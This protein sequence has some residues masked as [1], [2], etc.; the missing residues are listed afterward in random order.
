VD[1]TSGPAEGIAGAGR[2][3]VVDD[4]L[5]VR[6]MVGGFLRNA[7][8]RVHEAENGGAAVRC[9]ESEEFDVVITDL[10]MP[11]LDGFGV[12]E[13]VKRR[14][15]NTEVIIL[16]GSHAQDMNCAIKALRLGAHDFLTKPPSGPDE[17]VLTVDRALEKKRLKEANLRLLRQLEALSRTDALTGA[18]NRRAFDDTLRQERERARRY[19][20]SLSLIL[21]DL[22]HFKAVND[23]HGHM[24]GDEVLKE[25]VRLAGTVFRDSDGLYRYGGEEF[26]VLMP[27]TVLGGALLAAGRMVSATADTAFRSGSLTMRV[28][29][30]AGVASA[31]GSGL[32]T[33]D[34]TKAADEALYQAKRAGRSRAMAYGSPAIAAAL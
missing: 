3:L 23:T 18:L 30:S 17:V 25:F 33:I 12:L 8:Y 13:T 27:H 26:A 2:V 32:D 6:A 15:L 11:E 34:L 24:A 1:T 16:T 4:S 31:E 9:L 21:F 28:T 29:V 20:L 7:G 10:R 5:L 22:D 19:G 14:S